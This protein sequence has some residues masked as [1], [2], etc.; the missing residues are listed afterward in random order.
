MSEKTTVPLASVG[1]IVVCR[2]ASYREALK[3]PDEI[4]LVLE[5]RKDRAKVY[6]PAS[7]GEPWIPLAA[8]ARL[9]QP[10]GDSRVPLWMQRAHYLAGSLEMLF[11][12]IAHVGPDGCALR[13]FHGEAELT[14]FDQLRAGLGEEL[15]Y[16]RL[17]PAGLHK[18]ESAVAFAPRERADPPLPL[19]HAEE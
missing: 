8:L 3:I 11:L 19:P 16:W 7:R 1:D 15:R 13:L 6:L 17:L 9:R 2:D 14:R 10:I 12:E 18:I 5:A 4:G